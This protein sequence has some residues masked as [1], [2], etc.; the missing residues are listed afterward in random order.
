MS[1]IHKGY[2]MNEK[3]GRKRRGNLENY[4]DY[5]YYLSKMYGFKAIHAIPAAVIIYNYN[6]CLS[7]FNIL[8]ST[9]FFASS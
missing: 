2:R 3:M 5:F 1:F 9:I 8:S 7:S 4:Q 6:F